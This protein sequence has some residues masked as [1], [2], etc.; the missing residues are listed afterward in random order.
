MEQKVNNSHIIETD[1]LIVG[2]GIFGLCLAYRLKQHGLRIRILEKNTCGSGA[3]G[4]VLG[5]LMPHV[6]DQWNPKKQFQF[7]A[8]STLPTFIKTLEDET[9]QDAGYRKSGRIIP[10]TNQNDLLHAQHR[11]KESIINWNAGYAF[12]VCNNTVFSDTGWLH[13]KYTPQGYILDTLAATIDPK[14][15]I[16]TLQASLTPGTVIENEMFQ[17]YD[18][19]TKT[20]TCQSGN[21]YQ[22]AQTILCAGYE[23]FDLLAPYYSQTLGT[24]IKGQASL[25]LLK[26]PLPQPLPPVL[27]ANGVYVIAR[28]QNLCAVGSTSETEWSRETPNKPTQTNPDYLHKATDLCPALEGAQLISH[29]AGV[30][31]RAKRRDPMIGLIDGT[32]SLY[33]ATGGF[34]IGLGIAHMIAISV[35][36]M[37]I[38]KQ[39]SIVIPESFTLEYHLKTKMNNK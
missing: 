37:I 13:P 2:G 14:K 22:A 36:S 9:G 4:G 38:Q 7:E 35:A 26:E 31:P 17:T 29:W 8:L 39:N 15:Y 25:L 21:K 24:G 11:Q 18:K 32:D 1:I 3:S 19:T 23:T 16:Q 28:T 20:V 12:S 6:P 5:A 34:K 33:V 30:R 10:L 27:Y